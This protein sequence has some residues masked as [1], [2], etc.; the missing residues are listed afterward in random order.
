MCVL[1]A[2]INYN[3]RKF[4]KTIINWEYQRIQKGRP[5]NYKESI[6]ANYKFKEN[7]IKDFVI[8]FS[9]SKES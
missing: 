9:C 7:N 3:I 8:F 1:V 2:I 4:I 5:L 6:T